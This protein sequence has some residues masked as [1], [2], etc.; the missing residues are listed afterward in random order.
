MKRTTFL[1]VDRTNLH[2]FKMRGIAVVD[3]VFVR[4]EYGRK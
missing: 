1:V 4:N 3:F 2:Y